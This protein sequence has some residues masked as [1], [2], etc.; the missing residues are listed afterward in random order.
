MLCLSSVK[1]FMPDMADT[2]EGKVLKWYK[3]EG[4]L[5]VRDDILCDIATEVSIS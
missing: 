5:V 2:G 3:Q 4:D 1:I